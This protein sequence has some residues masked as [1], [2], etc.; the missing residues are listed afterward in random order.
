MPHPPRLTSAPAFATIRRVKLRL[1]IDSPLPE[2]TA[3]K[4]GVLVLL[5]VGG[6]VA[7]IVT[8]VFAVTLA[9]LLRG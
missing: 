6:L 4:I 3:P 1:P 8:A 7:L 2:K 5:G 9:G